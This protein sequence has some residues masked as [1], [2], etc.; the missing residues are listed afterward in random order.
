VVRCGPAAGVPARSTAVVKCIR[1]GISLLAPFFAPTTME[2]VRA[3]L[4]MNRSR[5]AGSTIA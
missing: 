4:R 5:I 2:S 1:S 3:A